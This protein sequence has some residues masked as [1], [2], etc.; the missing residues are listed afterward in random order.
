MASRVILL[1]CTRKVSYKS[2]APSKE[3]R[4][5]VIFISLTIS[6][7]ALVLFCCRRNKES[8]GWDRNVK[9]GIL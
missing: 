8:V 7:Y 4:I 9:E 3:I 6:S 1:L 2:S 5:I